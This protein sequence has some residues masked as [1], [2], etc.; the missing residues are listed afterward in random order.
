MLIDYLIGAALAISGMLALLVFGT[1]IIRMNTEAR[2][3]WQAQSAMAD[4][5][6]RKALY[7]AHSLASGALCDGVEPPW[8]VAWC[9]SPQVTSLPNVCVSVDSDTSRIVMRWGLEG[10]SGDHALIASRAL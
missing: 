3:H 6:A 1:D 10:C 2:E 7:Q 8:V 5:A 9:Q 4:F